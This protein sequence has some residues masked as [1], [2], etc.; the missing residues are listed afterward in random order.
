MDGLFAQYKIDLATKNE[1]IT[2]LS[3]TINEKQADID[4]LKKLSE[5]INHRD[6][7]PVKQLL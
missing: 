6:N 2:L 7:Q 5:E 1:Q 3:N 4:E